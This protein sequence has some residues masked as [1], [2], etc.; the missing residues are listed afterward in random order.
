[1]TVFMKDWSYNPNFSSHGFWSEN[2]KVIMEFCAPS[3]PQLL[4]NYGSTMSFKS[5]TGGN[6]VDGVPPA[7]IFLIFLE[8][9]IY[10]GF[11]YFWYFSYV[12]DS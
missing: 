6:L 10:F 5:F 8:W 3:L 11:K 9:Q 1:M 12:Y 4:S 7:C 2:N